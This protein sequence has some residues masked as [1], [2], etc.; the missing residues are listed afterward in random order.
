MAFRGRA[1]E[2]NC[3]VRLTGQGVYDGHDIMDGAFSKLLC[4]ARR[5]PRAQNKLGHLLDACIALC[6]SSNVVC[7]WLNVLEILLTARDV[8][9]KLD[10]VSD[11]WTPVA[12]LKL[13]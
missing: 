10:E 4:Q 7:Q 5:T 6:Y 9:K 11:A 13:P 3:A 12:K 8:L 1:H 2:P